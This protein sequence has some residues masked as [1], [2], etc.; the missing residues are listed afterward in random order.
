MNITGG[1]PTIST[2]M[3]TRLRSPPEMTAQGV[4]G[5]R[6]R[7]GRQ[8]R[9][10]SEPAPCCP[11]GPCPPLPSASASAPHPCAPRSPSAGPASPSCPAWPACRPRC[12]G[13]RR[14]PGCGREERSGGG[15][16]GVREGQGARADRAA[17]WAV[18]GRAAPSSSRSP[19]RQLQARAVL[20]VLTAARR[21]QEAKGSEGARQWTAAS[22]APP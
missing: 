12:R 22:H 17:D 3:L 6:W 8:R 14:G 16:E 2:P 7:R 10:G 4:A 15:G 19:S 20:Q 21:A 9:D 13:A 1:L 18:P 11:L 5:G